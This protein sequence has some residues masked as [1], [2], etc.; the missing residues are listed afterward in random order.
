MNQQDEVPVMVHGDFVVTKEQANRYKGELEKM[1]EQKIRG[2][3][4]NWFII[5]EYSRINPEIYEEEMNKQTEESQPDNKDIL[6]YAKKGA[7]GRNDK[8]PCGSGK[9]V[10]KCH[11]NYLN[12]R[13][14]VVQKEFNVV[15]ALAEHNRKLT[16][17]GHKKISRER[18]IDSLLEKENNEAQD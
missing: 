8:C 4:T 2:Q 10:K 18:F 15:N 9:K 1:N 11:S 13:H 14:F 3:R 5:D 6:E 7:L 17:N 12:I 16:D